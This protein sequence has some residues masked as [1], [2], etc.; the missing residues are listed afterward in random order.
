MSVV[1]P[2][3]PPE[4]APEVGDASWITR[5]PGVV[6]GDACIRNTRISV[7]GLVEARRL[8]LTDGEILDRIENLTRA[9]LTAAWV[10]AEAHSD[11]IERAILDN[12]DA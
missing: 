12:R 3:S 1:R 10:Y 8:G 11:E 7:W 5:T 2:V 6:G 4:R 9:D